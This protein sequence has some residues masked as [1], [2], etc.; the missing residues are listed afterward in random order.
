[1]RLDAPLHRTASAAFGIPAG[2]P[3]GSIAAAETIAGCTLS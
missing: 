3:A 1:M 2:W